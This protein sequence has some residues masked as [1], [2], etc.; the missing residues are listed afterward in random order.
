MVVDA[1]NSAQAK[2]QQPRPCFIFHI[3]DPAAIESLRKYRV[4]AFTDE[5]VE[6]GNC[7][8]ALPES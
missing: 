4:D 7:S 6:E 1:R 8:V 2:P 3:P 5:P